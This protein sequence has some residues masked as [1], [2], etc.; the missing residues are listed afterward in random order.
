[1]NKLETPETYAEYLKNGYS[2]ESY[3]YV[4]IDFACKLERKRDEALRNVAAT[5]PAGKRK[6]L[7]RRSKPA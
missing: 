1:M 3:P 7:A 5:M 2:H 6:G 4:R